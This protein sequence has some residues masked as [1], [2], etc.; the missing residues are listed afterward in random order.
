ML[1]LGT[2]RPAEIVPAQRRMGQATTAMV[3]LIESPELAAL[4]DLAAAGASGFLSHALYR[5]NRP[6]WGL[7][8][9]LVSVGAGVKLLHDLSR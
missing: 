1:P 4:T 2:S 5:N 9:A 6:T 7:I 3:P 8:W